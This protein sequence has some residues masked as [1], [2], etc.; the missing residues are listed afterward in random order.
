M[1]RIILQI[2]LLCL[3]L[4]AACQCSQKYLVFTFNE[5]FQTGKYKHG[6]GDNVWGIPY[7]SC[8]DGIN[9]EDLKPLFADDFLLACLSD[10]ST[11]NLSFGYYPTVEYSSNAN[12]SKLLKN[13]K[14]I[15]LT[16]TKYS[17]RN[18][19]KEIS[20]FVVPI[21]A[22]CSMHSFGFNPIIVY[23]IEGE[24]ELWNDFW[25][26][27]TQCLNMILG[28]DFSTFSFRVGLSEKK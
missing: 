8:L 9:E 23:T 17:F 19:R 26:Q 20:I 15:Q 16:T 10:T 14:K 28:H 25:N 11:C 1:K 6:T 4:S 13:R 5:T 7:D 27:P 22:T 21:I 3:S 24:F 12:A 2:T 18:S